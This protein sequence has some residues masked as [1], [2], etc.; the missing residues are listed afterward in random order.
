MPA[1][2]LG[3]LGAGLVLVDLGLALGLVPVMLRVLRPAHRDGG[4][5][6]PAAG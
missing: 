6:G 3:L 4:V 2:L 1:S 5:A